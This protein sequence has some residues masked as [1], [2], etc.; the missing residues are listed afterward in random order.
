M[1][2]EPLHLIPPELRAERARP[3][4]NADR[5]PTASEITIEGELCPFCR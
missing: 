2:E 4:S 1:H 5:G 3:S